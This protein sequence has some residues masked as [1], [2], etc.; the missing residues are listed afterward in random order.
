MNDDEVAN[1]YTYLYI[2]F[3]HNKV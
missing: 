3:R 2:H 1:M